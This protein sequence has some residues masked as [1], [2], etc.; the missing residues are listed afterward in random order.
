MP[1][2]LP[3]FSIL[4][5]YALLRDTLTCSTDQ[6][7]NA[8]ITIKIGNTYLTKLGEECHQNKSTKMTGKYKGAYKDGEAQINNTT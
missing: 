1:D 8:G 5:I 6:K 4:Y 2:K 3:F 7:V